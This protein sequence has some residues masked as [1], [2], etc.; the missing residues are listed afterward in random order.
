MRGVQLL[1][2]ITATRATVEPGTPAAL[3]P[4][5]IRFALVRKCQSLSN[6]SWKL[7]AST[8]TALTSEKNNN[9]PDLRRPLRYTA[10]LSSVLFQ[11]TGTEETSDVSAN[12]CD[13]RSERLKRPTRWFDPNQCSVSRGDI[14]SQ[15][16]ESSSFSARRSLLVNCCYAEQA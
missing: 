15:E 4:A 12:H 8:S 13:S 6:V 5:A 9:E 7:S 10:R 2:L 16:D 1:A 3:L 11:T 14:P